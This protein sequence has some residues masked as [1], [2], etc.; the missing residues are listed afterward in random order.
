LREFIGVVARDV[1]EEVGF[2][3]SGLLQLQDEVVLDASVQDCLQLLVS[4][5]VVV[6][7]YED[8]VEDDNHPVFQALENLGKPCSKKEAGPTPSGRNIGST[9]PGSLDGE[10][11]ASL[12][13]NDEL[14]EGVSSIQLD[15]ET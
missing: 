14:V 4:I 9:A 3:K 1:A 5:L 8:A 7:Q 11:G 6:S 15:D 12:R 10:Y 13:P 2:L